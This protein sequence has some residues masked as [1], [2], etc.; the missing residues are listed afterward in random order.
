MR[1]AQIAPPWLSIPPKNYGGTEN[2]VYDLVEAQCDLGHDV[3]LFAPGSTTTSAQLVSFIPKALR[4]EGAP[5]SEYLKAYYHLHQSIEA[6]SKGAF[7]I[8]HTHLSASAGLFLFPLTAPLAMH[9]VTTLHSRFPFDHVEGWTGDADDF[10]LKQWGANVPVI[11]ISEHA[12]AEVPSGLRVVDVVHNGLSLQH[13]P[14]PTGVRSDYLVWLG[15]MVPDKGPHLAIEAAKRAHR[16]IVLSGTIDQTLREARRYFHEVIEPQIDQQ[17]VHYVGPA[18]KKRKN[19]LLSQAYGFLNPIQWEEPFGMVMI[20]AMALG[21]PVISFSRGAAPELIVDGQTGFLVNDVDEMVRAIP[22]LEELNRKACRQHVEEHFSSR[23]MAE[24]YVEVY[25]KVIAH[26][27][28]EK[29]EEMAAKL[30][31][32][33]AQL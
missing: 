18:D 7:D 21:C 15:R 5:W 13:Y 22:R 17:N 24:K 12:R 2:V 10:Y 11:A 3:T 28:E 20:E 25:Q 19:A 1:I 4:E 30:Q 9:H 26:S 14:F 33:A 6:A 8:I 29:Q 27:K 23:I 16:P 32:I 31:E